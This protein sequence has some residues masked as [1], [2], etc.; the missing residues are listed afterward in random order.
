VYERGTQSFA[1]LA[2]GDTLC[3]NGKFDAGKASHTLVQIKFGSLDLY[4]LCPSSHLRSVWLKRLAEL[5][6]LVR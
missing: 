2:V 1:F 6:G 3:L 4:F 5:M